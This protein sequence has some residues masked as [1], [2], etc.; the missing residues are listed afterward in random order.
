[1]PIRE[2]KCP[3]CK[4]VEERFLKRSTGDAEV[5]CKK[6]GVHMPRAV[7]LP[8][9]VGESFWSEHAGCR[10]ESKEQEQ[11]IMQRK[12]YSRL[13]ASQFDELVDKHT[14]EKRVAIQKQD[15]ICDEYEAAV[16]KHGG[17]RA[18]ASEEVFSSERIKAG[19]FNTGY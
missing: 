10:V 11:L 5:T 8:A 6:C 19:D 17:D 2:Y 13:T 12:G 7:S 3:T 9:R 4:R 15:A 16:V 18:A 14:E 1:M